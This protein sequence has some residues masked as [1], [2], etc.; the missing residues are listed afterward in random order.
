MEDLEQVETTLI[1]QHYGLLWSI[2]D[3]IDDMVFI[4]RADERGFHYVWANQKACRTV[5]TNHLAG[6]RFEDV[7]PPTQAVKLEAHYKQ[8]AQM[9]TTFVYEDEIDT[10][11]GRKSYETVL[12]P[13]VLPNDAHLWFVAVVRDITERKVREWELQKLKER[14]EASEERYRTFLEHLP[15]AVLVFDQDGIIIYAN[16]GAVQLFGAKQKSEIVGVPIRNICCGVDDTVWETCWKDELSFIEKVHT[17]DD[18]TIY[19]RMAFSPIEYGDKTA[20]QVVMLDVTERVHYEEQ[21]KYLAFHDALTGFPN[22]RLFLDV[23]RESI[24]EAKQTNDQLAIVYIDMDHFKEVNDTF[25]HDMGDQLLK[26][27]AQRVKENIEPNAIPCRMGGDEFLLLLRGVMNDLDIEKKV[28]KLHQSMQK[29]FFINGHKIVVTTSIGIAIYPWHGST[30]KE[31][32]LHADQAL[33]R[34]KAKRNH[35]QFYSQEAKQAAK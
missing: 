10:P 15:G 17:L 2:F 21:L 33:Y 16:T 22:R 8:A 30:A 11:F 26:R 23:V 9:K 27:F 1:E 13:F 29:P 34:A 32:I 14:L 20:V 12:T 7:L 35:Y 3:M 25:G 24:E 5:G 6:K 28:Y 19:A 18:R 4:V 31:L